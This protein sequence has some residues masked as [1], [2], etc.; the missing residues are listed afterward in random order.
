MSDHVDFGPILLGCV[1]TLP[2]FCSDG[3]FMDQ[4]DPELFPFILTLRVM[5]ETI[6]VFGTA[7]VSG[8]S[9]FDIS[10]CGFVATM[11]ATVFL[12]IGG[13]TAGRGL[14]CLRHANPLSDGRTHP[15]TKCTTG[16]L[17]GIG[18]CARFEN[19]W[20]LLTLHQFGSLIPVR[21]GR[22]RFEPLVNIGRSLR[23]ALAH[24]AQP[25]SESLRFPGLRLWKCLVPI[26]ILS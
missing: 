7:E 18:S 24:V 14:W 10:L 8:H 26:S 20:F 21:V 17:F 4:F 9:G 15:C 3:R 11:P 12:C 23:G 19:G 1:P 2:A 16:R 25:C 22:P 6:F 5:V 13:G